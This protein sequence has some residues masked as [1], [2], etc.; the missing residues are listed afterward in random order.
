MMSMAGPLGAMPAGATVSTIK[1]E[2]DIN[3]GPLGGVAGG[4]GSVHQ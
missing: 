3:G 2:D 4:S 1:V